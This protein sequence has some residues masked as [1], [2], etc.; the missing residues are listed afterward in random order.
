VKTSLW[1]PF[2]P[3]LIWR[4]RRNALSATTDRSSAGPA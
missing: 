1:P 3:G 2:V 4:Y